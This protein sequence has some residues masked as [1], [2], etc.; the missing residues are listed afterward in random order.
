M[1]FSGSENRSERRR[2]IVRPNNPEARTVAF[3]AVRVV[4]YLFPGL[5]PGT[6]GATLRSMRGGLR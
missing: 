6:G 2:P 4:P 5:G 3:A 1:P